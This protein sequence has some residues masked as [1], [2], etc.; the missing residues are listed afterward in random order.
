MADLSQGKFHVAK[1]RGQ[2]HLYIPQVLVDRIGRESIKK[3]AEGVYGKE[4]LEKSYWT[5][6]DYEH[7]YM[8]DL[9]PQTL[10]SWT[11]RDETDDRVERLIALIESKGK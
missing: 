10:L 5:Q 2:T 1:F 9:P 8:L 11:K 6:S 4:I 7:S 3:L